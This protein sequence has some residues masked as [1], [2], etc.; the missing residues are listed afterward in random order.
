M[1]N[2]ADP[3]IVL[4]QVGFEIRSGHFRNDRADRPNLLRR[5]NGLRVLIVLSMLIL[6]NS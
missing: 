5:G 1:L 6:H 2:C 3:R 4:S